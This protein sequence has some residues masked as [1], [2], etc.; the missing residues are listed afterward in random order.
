MPVCA[1]IIALLQPSAFSGNEQ[2]P[3]KEI[4]QLGTDTPHGQSIVWCADKNREKLHEVKAGTV[5]VSRESF[6]F[7]S[8]EGRAGAVNWIVV[9]NPRRAF[10]QVVK[11]FFYRKDE[12]RIIQPTAQIHASATIDRETSAIG[13]NV[14]IE[15]NVRIGKNATIGHNTVILSGTEIGDNVSIGN[16]NTIGGVGFGYEKDEDGSYELIPHIGNVHIEDN[17]EIGNNVAIDRAVLGSTI[18]GKNVKIDNLV[19]IAHGVQIGENSLVIANAMV[20]GSVKIG[21]NVWVAPSSSII[22]NIAIGDDALIGMASNV[23]KPVE[24]G[25]VFAGNPAKKIR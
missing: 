20:A 21:K 11:A 25:S 5:I 2:A 24:A 9:E 1:D 8:A 6:D 12:Q 13:H 15:A 7:I 14:I 4:L 22:Q 23:L 19:H 16:N 3:V 10:L 17:A 18:I